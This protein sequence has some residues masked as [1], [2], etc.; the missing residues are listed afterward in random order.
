MSNII[1]VARGLSVQARLDGFV[2]RV[3]LINY[4]LCR[5]IC[6]SFSSLCNKTHQ[7]P[8]NKSTKTFRLI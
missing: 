8:L 2:H 7:H 1:A 4:N 3:F 5:L 6:P